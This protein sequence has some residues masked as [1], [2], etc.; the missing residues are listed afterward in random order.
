MLLLLLSACKLERAAS[1]RLPG[2]P[3]AADS[4]ALVEQD[5]AI[6]VQVRHALALY[7]RRRSRGEWEEIRESF[8]PGAVVTARQASGERQPRTVD[9][10]VE[11]LR[12]PGAGARIERPVHTHV[13]GYSDLADAWVVYESRPAGDSA[14]AVRGVDAFHLYRRGGEWRIAGLIS[15]PEVSGL[16]LRP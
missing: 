11:E 12:R 13:T 16:P 14:R 8:W 1:G 4:L 10:L 3:T 6:S 15:S 2:P 7:Y 9:Q 5:S